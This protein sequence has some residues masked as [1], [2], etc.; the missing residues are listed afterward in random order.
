MQMLIANTKLHGDE[1]PDNIA[2]ALNRIFKKNYFIGRIVY[3]LLQGRITAFRGMLFKSNKGIY[4]FTFS[5]KAYVTSTKT[6]S[7]RTFVLRTI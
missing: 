7:L 3:V 4:L 5:L 6:I 1:K 2:D